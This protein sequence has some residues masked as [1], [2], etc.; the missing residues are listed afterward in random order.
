M[1][2]LKL[3]EAGHINIKQLEGVILKSPACEECLQSYRKRLNHA[4]GAVLVPAFCSLNMAHCITAERRALTE[5]LGPGY[6][7]RIKDAD[8]A[9]SRRVMER[10]GE[11]LAELIGEHRPTMEYDLKY[12]N[13][14]LEAIMACYGPEMDG[15]LEGI[16]KSVCI[17]TWSTIEALCEELL[18]KVVATNQQLFP[19]VVIDGQRFRKLY[20]GIRPTYDKVLKRDAVINAILEHDSVSA[21]SEIRHAL[22][23][24][25]GLADE[26][27][28]LAVKGGKTRKGTPIRKNLQL[29]RYVNYNQ[30]DPIL[31][32]GEMVRFFVEPAVAKGYDLILE[33]DRW[34][35]TS[36]QHNSI[37]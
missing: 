21:L 3:S 15:M 35:S 31:F 20:L 2:P 25:A 23:H 1:R 22:V 37:P 16:F 9:A 19:G 33:M 11:H 28:M 17:Q 4:V 30:D 27:F 7:E 14:R 29:A 26:G 5:V 32:D 36:Q 34:L 18:T 12:I 10:L 8:E 6:M 24:K 13:H